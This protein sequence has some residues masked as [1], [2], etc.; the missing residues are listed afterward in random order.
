[1]PAAVTGA[2]GAGFT[3]REPLRADER[4][5]ERGD[6]RHEPD[7]GDQ[8]HRRRAVRAQDVGLGAPQAD[9]GGEHQHVHH[10]VERGR[11]VGEGDERGLHVGHHDGQQGEHRHDDPLH[12]EDA[13]LHAV[14]LRRWSAGGRKP[15]RAAASRPRDGPAIQVTT[16]ASAPSAMVSALARAAGRGRLSWAHGVP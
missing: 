15:R 2:A 16:D 10:E 5:D 1:M 6:A 3:S 7:A 9:R 4:H 11:H 13:H 12:G 14:L 8:P